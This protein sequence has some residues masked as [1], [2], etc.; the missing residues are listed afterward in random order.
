MKKQRTPESGGISKLNLEQ[1]FSYIK[2]FIASLIT[3]RN[4]DLPVTKSL[5]SYM[6]TYVRTCQVVLVLV[7]YVPIYSTLSTYLVVPTYL[8]YITWPGG[9]VQD[10]CT[11]HFSSPPRVFYQLSFFFLSSLLLQGEFKNYLQYLP[12]LPGFFS[13][14][15][16]TVFIRY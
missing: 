5:P 8:Q 1:S 3:M 14:M 11:V 6:Y 13:W 12:T 7:L 4:R 2:L 9:G 10:Q 16:F 15:P